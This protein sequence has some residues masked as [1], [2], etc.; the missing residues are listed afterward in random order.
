MAADLSECSASLPYHDREIPQAWATL[1]ETQ[2]KEIM[3]M[4]RL[5]IPGMPL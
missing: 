2:H 1:N 3:N 5:C 4:Y